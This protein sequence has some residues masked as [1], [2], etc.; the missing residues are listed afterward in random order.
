MV[1]AKTGGTTGSPFS[2]ATT[3]RALQEQW[4]IWWRFRATH[5]LTPRIRSGHFGGQPVTR[6]TKASPPF[7]RN[8]PAANLVYFSSNQLTAATAPAYMREINR[9][10]LM[11][12]H[13]YPT[14]LVALGRFALDQGLEL[15]DPLT[16]LTTGSEGLTADD[17]A[18]L[19]MAFG[20]TTIRQ[21][22]GLA[23]AVAN[24][25][26]CGDGML[27][28]DED[29]A[30]VEFVPHKEM[31]GLFHVVGT[32]MSNPITPF[33]R[34]D[35]GDFVRLPK[36]PCGCGHPGR[37]VLEVVGRDTDFLRLPSGA[38]LGPLNQIGKGV[39]GV[40]SLQL[41]DRGEQGVVALVVPT[42]HWSS[43]YEKAL[44]EQIVK[45]SAEPVAVEVRLHH[46]PIR[47]SA[48]KVRAVISEDDLP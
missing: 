2:F 20:V 32:A 1:T 45:R 40:N 26:E 47:T 34:Y 37:S 46:T 3:R 16:W 28:V 25:S 5:G 36:E 33:V 21:H 41:V 19:K 10:R 11:W 30:A 14:V 48:G 42:G 24:F 12:L 18:I 27:H 43:E 39:R 44:Q 6:A 22:Y 4:A 29:H 9:Q 7:W 15:H 38:L 8:N 13:G 17:R 31:G 35:T 23:E